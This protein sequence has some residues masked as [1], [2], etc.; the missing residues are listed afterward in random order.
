MPFPHFDLGILIGEQGNMLDLFES[1]PDPPTVGFG[2]QV[3]LLP[4]SFYRAGV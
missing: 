4:M 1:F 2:A 3:C